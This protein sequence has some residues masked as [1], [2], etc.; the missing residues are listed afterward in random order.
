MGPFLQQKKDS[1]QSGGQFIGAETARELQSYGD[2]DSGAGAGLRE[3]FVPVGSSP[4]KWPLSKRVEQPVTS[5]LLGTHSNA[6]ILFRSFFWGYISPTIERCLDLQWRRAIGV[7][8]GGRS[9]GLRLRQ[10]V[11]LRDEFL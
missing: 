4:K 11:R 1:S 8:C 2:I 9:F 10:S 6:H 3:R 7:K 5:P